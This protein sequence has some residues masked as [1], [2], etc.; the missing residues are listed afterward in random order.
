VATRFYFTTTNHPLTPITQ[1]ANWERSIAAAVTKKSYVTAQNTALTDYAAL[2]GSTT[3]SQ[4]RW[5][6]FLTT[7]LTADFNFT[8]A[9][10]FSMVVRGLEA[11]I[12]EDAH[13]AFQLWVM[14]GDTSTPR[15]LLNSSMATATE[16]TTAAQTRIFSAK[17]MTG[18]VNAL[19]GDRLLL[20]VGTHGVTP[21]NTTNITWRF[22]DPTAGA[23]F[24]LT[25]GLTTDLRP[26]WEISVN[27][28]FATTDFLPRRAVITWAELQV[29]E[30][31]A[32]P[33]D[34]PELRGPSSLRASRQ[35]HQ[36][37][38]T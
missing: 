19:T 17:V 25:S 30:S 26:W 37:L 10:T 4:T 6:S 32:A 35:M 8:T 7:P 20:E 38:A 36:L 27:P 11:N 15:G 13:L 23:D 12:A 18:N 16:L 9:H 5:M 21:G 34:T 22:G 31:A 1:Q 28:S 33:Q 24:A 14:Q 29:P 3:T 2:F